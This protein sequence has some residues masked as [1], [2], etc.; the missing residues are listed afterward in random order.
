MEEQKSTS[1]SPS[2]D[3]PSREELEQ[4]LRARAWKD[5]TF[6]QELLAEPKAVLQRD[7]AAW[8]PDGII[9]SDLSIKVVEEDEQ[10]I[11]FVL[12]PK[13]SDVFPD[14]DDGELV[15]VSGGKTTVGCTRS[16]TCPLCTR[17]DYTCNYCTVS[18]AMLDAKMRL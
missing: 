13:T 1:S 4:H 14:I 17:R 16:H 12:P 8:F 15:D 9:P 7:F 10:G 2:Q 3:R 5:D 18:C 6:R 11:C